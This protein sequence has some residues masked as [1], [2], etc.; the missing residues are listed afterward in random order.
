MLGRRPS[1]RYGRTVDGTPTPVA[2]A[3]RPPDHP[4]A[5]LEPPPLL[6]PVPGTEPRRRFH[7]RIDWDLLACGLHGHELVGTSAATVRSEDAPFVREA[8]GIRWHRCLRCE[9]WVPLEPPANPTVATPPAYSE[10]EMP[11]RGRQL[12]DRY[13][14]RL[15]VLDRIVHIIVLGALTAAI[16]LFAQNK[17]SLHHTYIRILNGFQIGVGG[18]GGHGGIL[19]DV[20]KLF[21]LTTG[22][23]Y[24]IGVAAAAYVAVLV[25]E[26]IGLWNA[27]RWAEYLTLVE[28]GVLVPVEAYE[29]AT[30]FS[31]L[32][33][34]TLV[35]NLA[36]VLY[37]LLAHRLFGLRGGHKAALEV[38]GA[39]G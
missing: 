27:R 12:R 29:L 25:A 8:D 2:P 31:V 26:A 24:L 21:K 37:L 13:V 14:L 32:K 18:P 30:S 1:G 4:R 15:I 10:I 7:W 39:E 22:K 9:A 5:S 38:Y 6:L 19:G 16:F 35:I 20:D 17:A 11:L 3:S 34:L 28:T 23:I 36:I 33:I